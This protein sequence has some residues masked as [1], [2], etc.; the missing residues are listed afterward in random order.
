MILCHY[1]LIAKMS[2][3]SLHLFQLL[4]SVIVGAGHFIHIHN[5]YYSNLFAAAKIYFSVSEEIR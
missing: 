2:C 5:F 1:S 3:F 4:H